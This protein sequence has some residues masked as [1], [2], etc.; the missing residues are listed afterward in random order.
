MTLSELFGDNPLSITVEERK[1]LERASALWARQF[2]SI[3]RESR[4]PKIK[5]R[6]VVKKAK[7]NG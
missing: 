6:I 5:T 2:D 3:I 1:F 7:K 4:G